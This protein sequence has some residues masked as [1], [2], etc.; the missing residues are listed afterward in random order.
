[1]LSGGQFSKR[2]PRDKPRDA[3]TSLIS[4]NDSHHV[5]LQTHLAVQL[6]LLKRDG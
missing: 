5:I 4:V 1:M 6:K 2:M 3:N